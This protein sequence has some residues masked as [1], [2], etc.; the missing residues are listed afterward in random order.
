MQFGSANTS[1]AL[2]TSI[3]AITAA[4]KGMLKSGWRIWLRCVPGAMST[5]TQDR[6]SC[7]RGLRSHGGAAHERRAG[8]VR[9][10]WL[11]QAGEELCDLVCQLRLLV[12][13]GM[14]RFRH[15]CDLAV[16]EI[17]AWHLQARF[18]ESGSCRWRRCW[19]L[20]YL[21]RLPGYAGMQLAAQ[22][23]YSPGFPHC[24]SEPTRD[25]RRCFRSS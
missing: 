23:K 19:P 17:A 13:Y 22:S 11:D 21:T 5:S 14:S 9:G 6:C 2:A 1:D 18:V 10:R 25:T 3:A 24:R 20:R 4:T 7:L 8:A 12:V 16:R 15:S